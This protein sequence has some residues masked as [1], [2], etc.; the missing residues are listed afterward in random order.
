[1]VEHEKAHLSHATVNRKI[2]ALA[3]KAN[4]NLN[5]KSISFH[6]FR[7][8]FMSASD[9]VI[10][11]NSA[12]YLCGKKTE[13]SAYIKLAKTAPNSFNK[14]K[15]RIQIRP[16]VVIEKETLA[17]ENKLLKDRL[18]DLEKNFEE[19]REWA[20]R[21]SALVNEKGQF[22]TDEEFKKDAGRTSS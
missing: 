18:K 1:M 16:E 17:T 19:L 21:D 12:K 8:Q 9:E 2:K 5:G 10:S 6:N 22:K 4:I 20:M 3:K 15:A 13:E 11:L 7:I 14:L